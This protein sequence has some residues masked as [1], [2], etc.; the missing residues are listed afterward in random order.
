[1]E[2]DL[3]SP[4]RS[5]ASVLNE[6]VTWA[7]G[8]S[9]LLKYYGIVNHA[10]DIDVLVAFA[11][12]D[13]SH[14]LLSAIA[15]GQ[16]G[17]SKPPFCTKHF[18]KYKLGEVETDVLGGF[19]I[20]HEQGIY[21]LQFDAASLSGYRTIGGI[22]VPLSAPEDWYV[23]YQLMPGRA[24]KADLIEAFLLNNGIRRPELL[25]QALEQNLPEKVRQRIQ[26]IM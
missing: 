7:L 15:A 14:Q 17:E 6:K 18:F 21:E 19:R 1:M 16:R 13:R 4:L 23:L 8:G 12:A 9:L 22:Q 25:K 2:I 11:D 26:K 10:N 20:R 3:D 5:I 24:E